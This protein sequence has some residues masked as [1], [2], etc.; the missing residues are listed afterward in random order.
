MEHTIENEAR[1]GLLRLLSRISSDE[2]FT[3]LRDAINS[4]FAE[5]IL[6]EADRLWDEGILSEDKLD[7]I[8]HEHLRTPYND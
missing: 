7:S 2:E 4:Y 1:Q 5:K 6:R 3:M 8:L